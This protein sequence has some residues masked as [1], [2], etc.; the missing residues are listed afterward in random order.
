MRPPPSYLG[1]LLAALERHKEYPA[2]ARARRIEGTA[3]L[4]FAI[5]RDGTVTSWRIEQSSDSAILD[6][7]VERMITRASPLPP[8]PENVPGDPVEL[9]VPVRFRLR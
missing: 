5:R 4:R 9:T 7:S 3:L 1:A 2:E 8:P 6:T